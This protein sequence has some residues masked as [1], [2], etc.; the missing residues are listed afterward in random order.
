MKKNFK[1]GFSLAEIL[2]AL[3]IIAVIATMGFSIAQKGIANAY[4][5]YYYTGYLGIDT[6]IKL[7]IKEVYE[8]DYPGKPPGTKELQKEFT[9]HVKST[10]SLECIP[11]ENGRK[12]RCTAPNGIKYHWYYRSVLGNT[13]DPGQ[14]DMQMIVP[15]VKTK[16]IT[17]TYRIVALRY[18]PDNNFNFLEPTSCQSFDKC[19]DHYTYTEA[20]R[21]N[22][23]IDIF[24]RKDLLAFSYE[25]SSNRTTYEIQC[26]KKDEE[27][28]Y[29][30]DCK[31]VQKINSDFNNPENRGYGSYK[32]IKSK[33]SEDSYFIKL[34]NPKYAY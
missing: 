27:G 30:K 34:V 12:M 2:I 21:K 14:I 18:I 8:Q 25:D 7:A 29:T 26:Q 28:E 11:E 20:D 9:N 19:V 31:L 16:D 6:A 33:A 17:K 3:T 1:L 24:N 32:D 23:Y 13:N 5:G 4:Q 15:A 10:L 22:G